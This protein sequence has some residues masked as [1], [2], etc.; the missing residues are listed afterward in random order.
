MKRWNVE[1]RRDYNEIFDNYIGDYITAET[2][3]KAIEIAK[4]WFLENGMEP[5]EIEDLEYKVSEYLP[6]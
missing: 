5:E 6:V 1:T 3:E 4:N 2:A